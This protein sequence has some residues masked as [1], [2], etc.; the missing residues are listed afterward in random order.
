[1]FLDGLLSEGLTQPLERWFSTHGGPLAD[2]ARAWHAAMTRGESPESSITS[3]E[4]NF[5][6]PV[7]E[8]FRQGLSSGALDYVVED[9]MSA[10][11]D[12]NPRHALGRLLDQYRRKAPATVVCEGCVAREIVRMLDRAKL[13]QA[14]EVRIRWDQSG[15]IEQ[16]YFGVYVITVRQPGR[17]SILS[18]MLSRMTRSDDVAPGVRCTA[19]AGAFDLDRPGQTLKVVPEA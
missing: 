19:F 2:A 10:V 5:P 14:V 6:E 13:E 12:P 1:M 8:L 11:G 3:I 9:M 4:P 18:A 17:E 7:G 16:R 15:F